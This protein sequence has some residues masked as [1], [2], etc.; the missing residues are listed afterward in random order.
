[1]FWIQDE[2]S[3]GAWV[4]MCSESLRIVICIWF[5]WAIIVFLR[6]NVFKIKTT[7]LK[8]V[9]LLCIEESLDLQPLPSQSGNSTAGERDAFCPTVALDMGTI[10]GGDFAC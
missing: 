3:C 7:L 1:M 5:K 2:T 10:E 6:L 4:C 8:P 9:D